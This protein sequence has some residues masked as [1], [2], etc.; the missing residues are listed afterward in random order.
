M[1]FDRHP[2]SWQSARSPPRKSPV[3][4]DPQ[5]TPDKL[6]KASPLDM[7][8]LQSA[9]IIQNNLV[10]VIN[11]PELL[12]D[13]TTLRS[14]DYF[15]QYG[16][17]LKCAL[18]KTGTHHSQGGV[19]Y[20]V[21]ITYAQEEEAALCIKACHQFQIAGHT[22]NATYGT[23]KYCS[24]FLSN[25]PCPKPNCLFLHKLASHKNTMARDWIPTNKHI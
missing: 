11:L 12:S 17:I 18:N 1:D 22:L 3:K 20:G 25:K 16:T 10:Y 19:S 23:T 8:F 5:L 6:T 13:E 2:T 14:A 15:G 24:F 7:S 21:Y 9:R 4:V